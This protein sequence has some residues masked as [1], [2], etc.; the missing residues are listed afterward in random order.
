MLLQCGQYAEATETL[1]YA[2]GCTGQIR[3]EITAIIS[4]MCNALF[5]SCVEEQENLFF[6]DLGACMHY[7][8]LV[9]I[10]YGAIVL[11]DGK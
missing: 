7:S 5:R 11:E 9:M 2:T 8:R 4:L 10:C 3:L 1:Y 6:Y